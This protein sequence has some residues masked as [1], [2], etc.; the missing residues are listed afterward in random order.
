MPRWNFGSTCHYSV[1]EWL[2]WREKSSLCFARISHGNFTGTPGPLRYTQSTMELGTKEFAEL[3]RAGGGLQW[4]VWGEMLVAPRQLFWNP[5]A[6]AWEKQRERAKLLQDL[7]ILLEYLMTLLKS[8][9]LFFLESNVLVHP[10]YAMDRQEGLVISSSG[11]DVCGRG[12]CMCAVPAI[13]V[14]S[15]YVFTISPPSQG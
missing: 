6:Q 5:V 2:C 1:T 4:G 10:A 7:E 12:H 11:S 8:L 15:L 9:W 3:G 13:S 14:P